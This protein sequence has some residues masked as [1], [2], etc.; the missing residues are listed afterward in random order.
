MR[1]RLL[2]IAFVVVL[3]AALTGSVLHYRKAFTPVAWVTL[4]ADRAGL[5]LTEGADVK[6]RGVP[7]GEVRSV[8][9]GGDGAVLRLALDPERTGRIPADVT[10]RLLPKTL[11]GERYVELVP[12]AGGGAGPIRDGAV[13]DQD[14]S[15]TAVELERV[16]DEALPLLQSIR[17]DQL[18]ATLGALAAALDGRG[19][20]LGANVERLG[21]YLRELNPAMPT[22]A[23]DVRRLATV[24]DS[25]DA[26]LPDLLAL[27]RDVTVTARTVTD[28]RT[29]LA[30]FLADTTGTAETA[31]G[32][33]DRHGDQLIR[34]GAVS[35]PVL[36]LLATYAPEYPCLMTG[37]VALQPRVEEVFAG[38]RMHITL[39][40]TRDGGAYEPGRDEPVYGA[41]NGPRCLGLPH[42]KVP[43]P[44]HPVDDGYD[45]SGERPR[46]LLPVGVPAAPAK[47]PAGTA[48]P[49]GDGV[50]AEMGQA[51]TGEERSLVKPLVGALTGVLPAEVPDI[52]VL[53]WGP[54]LRGGVVNAR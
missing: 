8:R 31:E 20:R 27:L 38:G 50:P 23:E 28:Q 46:P 10:A 15:S 2:G 53:L 45:Y 34:L 18:A 41:K 54:L 6:V 22:I 37:L 24:L 11:F 52:A 47:Q 14:R 48:V 40:V 33:L 30:A 5:Q 43:A 9:S 35:R 17:P 19:E 21:A 32:F 3:T 29:Q 36:E 4:H 1:Q 13:I 44:E 42:P 26:V 39:E 16:L 25:Y 7:V 51:A 49:T 12:P